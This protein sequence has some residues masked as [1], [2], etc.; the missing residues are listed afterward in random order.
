MTDKQIRNAIIIV[1]AL[2]T[3]GYLPEK[4]EV[5]VAFVSP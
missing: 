1:T 5:D 2:I 3:Y 4:G